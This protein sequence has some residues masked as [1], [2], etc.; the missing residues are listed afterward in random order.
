KLFK[1][2]R[3]LE[4]CIDKNSPKRGRGLYSKADKTIKP[5][6]TILS[7][8]P[9][10]AVLDTNLLSTR[11]SSCFLESQDFDD[12]S[13]HQIRRCTK[14]K[15]I[16]YCGENCQRLDWISHKLECK[17]LVNYAQLAQSVTKANQKSKSR[18]GSIG[19]FTQS[20][21]TSTIGNNPDNDYQICT[22]PSS[23]VRAMARLIW[24]K[25]REEKKD[26]NWWNG[27]EE[28]HSQWNACNQAQKEKLMGLSMTLSRYIGAQILIEAIS[29]ASSLLP[30]CSRFLDNSFTLTSPTLDNI[31]VVLSG[32]A[33]FINHSC[34]PNAVVIFP[35]G[36][37]GASKKSG[38]EWVK[39][40]ALKDIEPGDEILTSYVDLSVTRKERQKDLAQRMQFICDCELCVKSERDPSFVDPRDALKCPKCTNWFSLD[41][42]PSSSSM[43][44]TT[45]S[46]LNT[47][48]SFGTNSKN[49]KKEIKCPDCGFS[50][51]I[52]IEG[53]RLAIKKSGLNLDPHKE[54]EKA[55]YY[56]EKAIEW[57]ELKLLP[58]RFGVGFYPIL[59]LRRLKMISK[60]ICHSEN[61]REDEDQLIS[62]VH[63]IYGFGHPISIITKSTITKWLERLGSEE[64]S[65]RRLEEE[66]R[67][68]ES[69]LKMLRCIK[70]EYQLK[71]FKECLIG[72]GSINNGGR[73]GR[74]MNQ[75]MVETER[76][77]DTLKQKL[78]SIS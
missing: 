29:S 4:V 68:L 39:V 1:S 16:A 9:H 49:A 66:R 2:N 35:E 25:S 72:F 18:L 59:N 38:K 47:R 27:L 33:A 71:S 67:N 21:S 61:D 12:S 28:L 41:S 13:S 52:D 60:L 10:V 30:F 73:L 44:T 70:E 43:S 56:A 34:S 7:L 3:Y 45:S 74:Y 77:I 36:G 54:P 46:S 19:N 58:F 24:N 5:G 53:Q 57:L 63:L 64:E 50:R 31:G 6:F 11:C 32:S 78:R 22:V 23:S 76:E 20:N 8:A 15:V 51:L 69:S 62:G 42:G 40:I 55:A 17:A 65:Q 48:S 14:C 26:P 75:C 37:E